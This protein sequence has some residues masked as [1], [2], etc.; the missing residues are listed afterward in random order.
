MSNETIDL[1]LGQRGR[2]DLS[3]LADTA[4]ALGRARAALRRELEASEIARELPGRLA[5]R[6][7]LIYER[8]SRAPSLCSTRLL[9]EWLSATH[10]ASAKAAFGEI[11]RDLAPVL[12]TDAGAP[13]ENPGLVV[14]DY[15]AGVDFHRTEGGWDGHP[16]MGFVHSEMIFRR[17]IAA[18]RPIDV[19]QQRR[20][21][22]AAAPPRSRR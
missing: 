4:L 17:I 12:A 11:E 9:T 22:A 3:F 13:A 6:E 16:E 15:Y 20:T 21:A 5:D 18:S 1:V 2:A 8:L 14:P 10:G 7:G 19:Y